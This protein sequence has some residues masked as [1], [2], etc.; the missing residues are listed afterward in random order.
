MRREGLGWNLPG[1]EMAS[2]S[3]LPSCAILSPSCLEISVGPSHDPCVLPDAGGWGAE[4][5]A[6]ESAGWDCSYTVGCPRVR[7][8]LLCCVEDGEAAAT[9]PS[10]TMR[11]QPLTQAW[12]SVIQGRGLPYPNP[13]FSPWGL[14]LAIARFPLPSFTLYLD[15]SL[16]DTRSKAG[17]SRE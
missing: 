5:R 16:E 15:S 4:G 11:Q 3:S 17:P 7:W 9:T 1:A 14:V 12:R 8:L 13:T 6:P 2:G 10:P